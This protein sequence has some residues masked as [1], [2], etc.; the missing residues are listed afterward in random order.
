MKYDVVGFGNSV[1]D[2]TIEVEEEFLKE[3]KSEIQNITF[4]Y[5]TERLDKESIKMYKNK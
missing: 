4:R 5:A 2:I 1:L 3:N